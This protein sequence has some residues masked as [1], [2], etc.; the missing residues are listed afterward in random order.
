MTLSESE[1]LMSQAGVQALQGWLRRLWA[2][3]ALEVIQWRPLRGGAVKV[4]GCLLLKGVPEGLSEGPGGQKTVVL[5]QAGTV[6]LPMSLPLSQDYHVQKALSEAGLPVAAPLALCEDPGLI[7]ERFFLM[8]QRSGVAAARPLFRAL[9]QKGNGASLGEAIVF[10]LGVCLGQ[11]QNQP[12]EA[13]P[14]SFA[15]SACAQTRIALYRTWLDGLA[16]SPLAAAPV[17]EWALNRL[18]DHAPPPSEAVWGHGDFRTGN[19]LVQDGQLQAVLDWEF[20]GPA[21]PMEDIGYLCAP[22]WRY[23]RSSIVGGLGSLESL[24]AGYASVRSQDLPWQTLAFWQA[25]AMARW[26]I[27][28]RYQSWR[29]KDCGVHDLDLALTSR[30]L[31]KIE[32]DLLQAI[33]SLPTH[34]KS[35]I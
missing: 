9:S 33:A 3:P 4:M 8:E 18:E 34:R 27:L 24:R 20:A 21:M 11:L 2:A 12:L 23:G 14:G 35:K 25:M 22:C 15:M 10:A 16:P 6:P 30:L 29:V 13:F 1:A 31:P 19:Y 32:Q 28:A 7:G 5:R 17:L 26:A